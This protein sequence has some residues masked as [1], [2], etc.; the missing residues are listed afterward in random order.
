MKKLS[1]S[2]IMPALNEEEN[3]QA[4]VESTLQAFDDFQLD[5]EVIVVNDGST[6]RTPEIVTA[7]MA[8]EP[9]LRILHHERPQGIGA[10]FWD[11]ITHAQGTIVTMF[12]GDNEND[13]WETLRYAHLLEHVDIVIPFVFNKEVRSP[14][15]NVLSDVFRLII[16]GT[17]WVNFNYTNGTI[18]YRKSILENISSCSAGFFFQTDIVVRVV[19]RGYLFAEVP[20][21]LRVREH[22]ASKAVSWASLQK[23][24]N[25]YLRL[26]RD[27]YFRENQGLRSGFAPDSLTVQRYQ[28]PP[29]PRREE[30]LNHTMEEE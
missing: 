25:G 27:I 13:P 16:N 2:V 26:V 28:M 21:R 5:G 29:A 18:L 19:K 30:P 11:G 10:A 22:G 23:V 1:L 4:A 20:Y 12:P 6:D 24:I 9:R 15:R 3:I 8:H 14:L 7:L 17:F